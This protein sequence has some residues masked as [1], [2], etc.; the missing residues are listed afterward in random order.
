MPVPARSHPYQIYYPA[1]WATRAYYTLT[2]CIITA[3]FS[4]RALS[5]STVQVLPLPKTVYETAAS[6][7]G[8]PWYLT[9][10]LYM[11]YMVDPA[12]CQEF[13]LDIAGGKPRFSSS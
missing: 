1:N 7:L 9:H 4:N 13:F 12:V 6:L 10:R 8:Q 11:Q 2:C 5:W 3:N